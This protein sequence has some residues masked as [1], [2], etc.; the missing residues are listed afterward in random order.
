MVISSTATAGWIQ[1]RS[2]VTKTFYNISVLCSMVPQRLIVGHTVSRPGMY[3]ELGNI[4]RGIKTLCEEDIYRLF[5]RTWRPWAAVRPHKRRSFQGLPV[6]WRLFGTLREGEGT[7]SPALG[8]KERLWPPPSS[9]RRGIIIFME[10]S[11]N[12]EGHFLINSLSF[13]GEE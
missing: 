12:G 4:D 8:I 9:F 11:G 10:V 2:S 1:Y 5:C 7:S 13:F 3:K 6:W